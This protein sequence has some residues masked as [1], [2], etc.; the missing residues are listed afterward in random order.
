MNTPYL[1]EEIGQIEN[2]IGYTEPDVYASLSKTRERLTEYQNIKQN[3]DRLERLEEAI[4]G[5]FADLN[6]QNPYKKV[7]NPESYS[8]YAEGFSDA[9]DIAEQELKKALEDE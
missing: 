4:K 5:I 6:A 2:Y 3:L 1:D 8:K 9:L 7:G